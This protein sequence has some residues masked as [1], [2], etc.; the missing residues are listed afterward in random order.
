MGTIQSRG[1]PVERI[2]IVGDHQR[3]EVDDVVEVRWSRNPLFKVND[4]GA[5]RSIRPET[6]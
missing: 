4:L 5:R 3:L 1:T 6:R 2:E